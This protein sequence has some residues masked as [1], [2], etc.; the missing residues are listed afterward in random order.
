MALVRPPSEPDL[1][2]GQIN[3]SNFL[4]EGSVRLVTKRITVS[5]VPDFSGSQSA[6]TYSALTMPY[7]PLSTLQLYLLFL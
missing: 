3:Y 1:L 7:P 5:D 6:F 2:N 4:G